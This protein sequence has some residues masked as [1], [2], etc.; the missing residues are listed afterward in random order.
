MTEHDSLISGRAYGVLLASPAEGSRMQLKCSKCS[1]PI[2]RRLVRES[3]QLRD[4]SDVTLRQLEA[5]LFERQ[6][7]LRDAMQQRAS[8]VSSD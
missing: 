5:A 1:K 7:A 2:P 6:Q 4:T 3:Q 8:P